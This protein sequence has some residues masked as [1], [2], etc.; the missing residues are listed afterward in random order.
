[1]VQPTEAPRSYLVSTPTGIVRRNHHHLTAIPDGNPRSD[2]ARTDSN[3]TIQ[4]PDSTVPTTR[5]GRVSVT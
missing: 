2:T 4:P 3:V 5:S 1:M